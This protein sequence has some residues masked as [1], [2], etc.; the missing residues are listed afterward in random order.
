MIDR[1]RVMASTRLLVAAGLAIMIGVT[2]CKDKT[3]AGNWADGQIIIDGK[4]TDWKSVRVSYYPDENVVIGFCN[5]NDRLNI[6]M[7]TR[8]PKWAQMIRMGGI[9]L[10]IDGKGKKKKEFGLHFNGGPEGDGRGQKSNNGY[11]RSGKNRGGGMGPDGPGRP[12]RL[13]VMK[14]GSDRPIPIQLNGED[15]PAAMFDTSQGF[16]TYEFS[17]PLREN[18]SSL[19]GVA[20]DSERKIALGVIWGESKRPEGHS[21]GMSG[22]MTGG[23]PDGMGGGGRGGRGGKGGQGGSRGGPAPTQ[24][25]EIWIKTELASPRTAQSE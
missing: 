8:D 6:L 20:V 22:G 3:V 19:Y 21:G 10:W 18:S 9:T 17:V 13:A 5:D 23:M 1:L 16:F 15:G 25:Q 12:V 14:K 11:N 4:G 2:G 24:R 7:R